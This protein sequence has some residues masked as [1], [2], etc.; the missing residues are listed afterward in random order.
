NAQI[1]GI[2]TAPVTITPAPAGTDRVLSLALPPIDVNLLG[3]VLQ[4]SQIQVNADAVTGNGDLLGNVLTTLLNTL[5]ATPQ[6]LT[7]LNNN[8]NALLGQVVGVLNAAS[9]VLPSNAVNSLSQ[10]LQTLALPNLVNSSGTAS[11]PILNLA[12][13]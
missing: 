3:L 4:T 1:P 11:A 9:L 7:T 6:N 13:A 10:V 12:I 8:L 2:P 5:G